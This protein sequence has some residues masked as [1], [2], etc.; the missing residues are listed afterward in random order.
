MEQT[1]KTVHIDIIDN[2]PGMPEAARLHLFEPFKGSRKP[3]GSGLGIA[4]AHE[5]LRAHDGD[6]T[7]L[8]SDEY[9]TTF[10]LSLID[11]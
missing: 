2:G 10:R 5:I 6:L 7:L 8:K 9:G 1:E 4:I 11:A 3:G